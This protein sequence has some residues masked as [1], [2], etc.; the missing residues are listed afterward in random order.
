MIDWGETND[1]GKTRIAKY[2]Y[3]T[4]CPACKEMNPHLNRLNDHLIGAFIQPVVADEVYETRSTNH[5]RLR[6]E[7]PDGVKQARRVKPLEMTPT[8]HWS[9][10]IVTEGLPFEGDSIKR[11]ELEMYLARRSAKAYMREE[12]GKKRDEINEIL[13]QVFKG[14]SIQTEN[15]IDPFKGI[16]TIT[17]EFR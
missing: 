3:G 4:R 14:R 9:D 16:R 11:L 7:E 5:P 10:R 12:T 15:G 6:K 1:Y 2:Y 13:D 17:M 8:I